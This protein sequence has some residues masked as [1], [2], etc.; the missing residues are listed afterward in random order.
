MSLTKGCKRGARQRYDVKMVISMREG[1][2][3]G[4]NIPGTGYGGILE[5]GV[6]E[7]PL[8]LAHGVNKGTR[9]PLQIFVP[10]RV[11]GEE[12]KILQ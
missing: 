4:N 12:Q 9:G 1:R 10:Q 11:R 6:P 5:G 8:Q 3:R 2:G 7:R